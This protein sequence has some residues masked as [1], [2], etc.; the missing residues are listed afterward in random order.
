MV[1]IFFWLVPGNPVNMLTN[2]TLGRKILEYMVAKQLLSLEIHV[3]FH[4]K[5]TCA[6]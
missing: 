2:G 6:V 5:F 1:Y 4:I 3:K